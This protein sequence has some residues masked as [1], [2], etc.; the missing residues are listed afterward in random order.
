MGLQI[1]HWLSPE[2]KR[3]SHVLPDKETSRTF[4]D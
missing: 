2:L 1:D 4:R 3:P